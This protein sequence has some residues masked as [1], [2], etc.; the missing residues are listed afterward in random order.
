[1]TIPTFSTYTPPGVYVQNT[2]GPI[3]TVS[4]VNPQILAICGPA[5]GY[6]TATQ[7]F[8]IYAAT[9]AL[10]T[11]TGVFTTA[12]GGPP[13]IAAPTVIITG[14]STVLTEGVDYSF[15]VTPDPSGISALAITSVYRVSSSSNISDG[16]QVT[17][18]YNYADVTYYQPQTFTD[19][20]SVVNAY[21]QPLVS[22][23]PNAPNTSQVAN[24]LSYA[25]QI[26]F[27]AGANQLICVACNPADG[28]LEQ[29]LISAYAKLSANYAATI[30]VPVFP[31][32]LGALS[33]PDTSSEYAQ[34]LASDLSTACLAASANG[35]PRIGFFGLP[36]DYSEGDLSIPDLDASLNSERLVLA[37]PEIVLAYNSVTR[38]TFSASACYLAVALGAMLS[39]LPVNTGL[40]GQTVSGFVGLTAAEVQAMTPAFMNTLA[41]AGTCIVYQSRNNAMVVRQG[42][43]T[44]MSA[45]NYREISL[46]RQGDALLVAIQAGLEN[47]GLIGSPITPNMVATVQGAIVSIL[48]Q[49]VAQNVIISY[50]NLTVQQQ[51]Y[52]GGD[53][54]IIT[55]SF[56][57][58]PAV[59]LNYI[60]VTFAINLANGLVATQSAQNASTPVPT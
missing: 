17:I 7:S 3:V 33:S 56:Q 21:G 10:L 40:T 57:Y 13:A 28:T 35:Y 50:T 22:A 18:T 34:L 12:Q 11:F 51:A 26:A 58:S 14:T 48:Q 32:Y 5:L 47:S 30:L 19:P 54:T 8:Q 4:G 20:T 27:T 25:A 44:N 41:A 24:P 15:T 46:V 53:P 49:C 52:P 42:L 23:A 31:D 59:P 45:L 1:V 16:Q 60:A 2:S 6:R 39:A 9:A 43:T 38:Q 37:Y 55:A 29:Q 36:V